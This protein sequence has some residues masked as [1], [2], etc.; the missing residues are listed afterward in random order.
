MVTLRG[1]GSKERYRPVEKLRN[2]RV[3][4]LR[5]V[6]KRR[7]VKRLMDFKIIENKDE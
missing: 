3:G 2:R 1:R 7:K 4:K 5:R 6:I